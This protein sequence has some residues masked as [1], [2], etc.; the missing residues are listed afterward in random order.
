MWGL[1]AGG[2]GMM[3]TLYECGRCG[4]TW[5]DAGVY[6]R[7]CADELMLQALRPCQGR[8]RPTGPEVGICPGRRLG[9]RP[10]LGR[11]QAR[12]CRPGGI[13]AWITPTLRSPD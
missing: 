9:H 7:K 5:A 2:D 10:G 6:C 3:Q 4:E 12:R 1:C 13:F 8:K 11:R